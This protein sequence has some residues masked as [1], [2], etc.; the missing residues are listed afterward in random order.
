MGQSKG[1]IGRRRM[2]TVS[3]IIFA[4]VAAVA[5][6]LL[7]P[8]SLRQTQLELDP[9]PLP[10]HIQTSGDRSN[11]HQPRDFG[12]LPTETHPTHQRAQKEQRPH[13]TLDLLDEMKT[14][15]FK[16]DLERLAELRLEGLARKDLELSIIMA[17]FRRLIHSKLDHADHTPV[18]EQAIVDVLIHVWDQSAAALDRVV[19]VNNVM[20]YATEILQTNG[21]QEFVGGWT[22]ASRQSNRLEDQ[23]RWFY[24]P[25]QDRDTL[26]VA[27]LV[28]DA[29]ARLPQAG[30]TRFRVPLV[31]LFSHTKDYVNDRHSYAQ[32]YTIDLLVRLGAAQHSGDLWELFQ[33]AK[34]H[35]VKG[36]A[37]SAFLQLAGD[38]SIVDVAERWAEMA[39]QGTTSY[40]MMFELSAMMRSEV[41][42]ETAWRTTQSLFDLL[43]ASSVSWLRYSEAIADGLNGRPLDAAPERQAIFAL[44]EQ[45][46]SPG[47]IASWAIFIGDA[48]RETDDSRVLAW[49][50][51][52]LYGFLRDD[53]KL[54][55][56][57]ERSHV[58]VRLVTA[59]LS[60][61]STTRKGVCIDL[62]EGGYDVAGA[63]MISFLDI[64][65][66]GLLGSGYGNRLVERGVSYER[67]LPM[68]EAAS[69]RE[70]P[71]LLDNVG[72]MNAKQGLEGFT[73]AW[74]ALQSGATYA[75]L[76]ELTEAAGSEKI[77]EFYLNVLVEWQKEADRRASGG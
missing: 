21:F 30:S 66:A 3:G 35:N 37:L 58:V 77:K 1:S 27:H 60:V 13:S 61:L 74:V 11:G 8:W 18:L 43:E 55:S 73:K 71:R 39:S 14:A 9:M 56:D 7:Q 49:I 52:R 38:D 2:W 31:T 44:M 50:A 36:A 28:D 63:S 33:N 68:L 75:R 40:E 34:L 57:F 15:Y 48:F 51:D 62:I 19:W 46:D 64:R 5:L 10:D 42:L 54:R 29:I 72:W 59:Y 76:Q 69:Q 45:Q 70:V 25:P 23:R 24:R 53:S 16:G 41:D 17:Y 4:A 12:R 20:E 47:A 65:L 67:V 26:A 22:D 32:I 6:I